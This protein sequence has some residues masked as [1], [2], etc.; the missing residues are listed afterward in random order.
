MTDRIA[1]TDAE[2]QHINNLLLQLFTAL[3]KV[4]LN[5]GTEIIGMPLAEKTF[6]HPG[7]SAHATITR[8][9]GL[10]IEVDL[11]EVVT[12]ENAFLEHRSAF[13]KAGLLDLKADPKVH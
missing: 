8:I 10:K 4:T 3:V 1:T 7:I 13:V 11:L 12:V 2:T 9:D 5:D 6:H